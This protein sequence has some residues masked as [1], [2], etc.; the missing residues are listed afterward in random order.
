[1]KTLGLAGLALVLSAPTAAAAPQCF[2]MRFLDEAGVLIPVNPP[3]VGIMIGTRPLFEGLPPAA[4]RTERGN[5]TPCPEALIASARKVF[6]TSCTSEEGRRR[7]AAANNADMARVNKRCGDL[8][9]TL[10]P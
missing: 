3:L 8:A 7:A 5:P 10:A 9:A 4:A 2:E 6:E 1:M